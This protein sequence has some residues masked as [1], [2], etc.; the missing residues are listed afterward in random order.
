MLHSLPATRDIDRAVTAGVV[1]YLRERGIESPT[2]I[3]RPGAIVDV[4]AAALVRLIV[5]ALA[6]SNVDT[7]NRITCERLWYRLRLLERSEINTK[8]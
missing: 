1:R 4:H 8:L 6:R 3:I 7:K 2:D 5:Q